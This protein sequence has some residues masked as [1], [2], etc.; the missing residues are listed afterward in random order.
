MST[1]QQHEHHRTPSNLCKHDTHGSVLKA[2]AT[3]A[4]T[5]QHAGKQPT[6]APPTDLHHAPTASTTKPSRR[7]H[8]SQRPIASSASVHATSLWCTCFG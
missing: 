5:Q 2:L 3:N 6:R 8:R 7:A 1:T 4:S